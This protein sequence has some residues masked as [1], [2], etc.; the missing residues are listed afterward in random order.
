MPYPKR[1][2]T[3]E[4]LREFDALESELPSA[5]AFGEPVRR[6]GQETGEA[7]SSRRAPQSPRSVRSK[8]KDRSGSR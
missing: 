6:K 8:S 7:S 3:D 4:L 1:P 2:A 5:L